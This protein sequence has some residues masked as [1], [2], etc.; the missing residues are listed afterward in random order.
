MKSNRRQLKALASLNLDLF[1]PETLTRP[2]PATLYSKIQAYAGGVAEAVAVLPEEPTDADGLP[3]TEQLYRLFERYNWMYF[4]G[5]LPQAAIEYSDRMT[6]AGAYLPGQ[7]LIR[8]GRK[9]HRIFPEDIADT[10]KHEMIHLRHLNH[11]AAFREEADRVGASLRARSHPALGKPPRYVYVCD[12]CGTEYPRQKRLRMASCG[13]CSSGGRYDSR[14]K[15][16]RE[17]SKG[18]GMKQRG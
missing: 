17:T 13:I 8:I 14:F 2:A 15:L 5:R 11:N 18:I 10:L 6:S 1:A 12:A 3:S 16:R 9:Y 4:Q 7:R